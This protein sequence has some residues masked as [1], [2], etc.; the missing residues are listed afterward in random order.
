MPS[1]EQ[2]YLSGHLMLRLYGIVRSLSLILFLVTVFFTIVFFLFLFFF[3]FFFI[4]LLSCFFYEGLQ[5]MLMLFQGPS[6]R[7]FDVESVGYVLLDAIHNLIMKRPMSQV[8]YILK[9]TAILR[10]EGLRIHIL[11]FGLDFF[12]SVF[13][14]HALFIDVF[15]YL[16]LPFIIVYGFSQIQEFAIGPTY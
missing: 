10:H 9:Y 4:V 2:G 16:I 6:D 11:E 1:F 15:I 5:V 8:K 13:F 3:F 12:F 7:F 14:R